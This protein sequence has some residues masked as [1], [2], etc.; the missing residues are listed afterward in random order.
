MS[1]VDEVGV[2]VI[3][4]GGTDDYQQFLIDLAK[5]IVDAQKYTVF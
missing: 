1:E 5:V 2:T 4:T 3:R